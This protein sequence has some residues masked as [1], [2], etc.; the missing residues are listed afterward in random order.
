MAL[1]IAFIILALVYGEIAH[2]WCGTQEKRIKDQINS[3]FPRQD[4]GKDEERR[5]KM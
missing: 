3:R 4:T 1:F 5:T 2:D